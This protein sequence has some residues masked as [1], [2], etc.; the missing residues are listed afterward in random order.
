M[1]SAKMEEMRQKEDKELE[2]DLKALKKELFDMRFQ[3][4]TEKLTNP[5]RISA[6]RKD[7]ARIHTIVRQ[8]ELAKSE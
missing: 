3:S 7:I 2:L 4:T 8:R 5:S 1:S 6:I